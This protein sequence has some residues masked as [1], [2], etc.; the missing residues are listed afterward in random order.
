M[1]YTEMK[2]SVGVAILLLITLVIAFIGFIVKEKGYLEPSHSYHFIVDDAS[3]LSRGT[4]LNYSGFTVALINDIKLLESGKAQ[5]SFEL[6]QR[7][8]RWIRDNTVLTVKRPL[9]GSSYIVI[10]PID[11]NASILQPNGF[12]KVDMS[13]DINDIIERLEPIVQKATHTIDNITKITDY[14]ADDKSDLI[15]SIHNINQITYKLA[16][17][18]SLLT[19]LTGDSNA[20]QNFIISLNHLSKILTN[21]EK[22]SQDFATISGS[23]DP[24]IITPSSHAIKDVGRIMK[25]IRGKLRLLHGTIKEVG[26]YKHELKNIRHEISSGIHKSNKIINKVDRILG[27]NSNQKVELP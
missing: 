25:D 21:L 6:S 19:S 27:G 8:Q 7:N 14:L 18:D 17:N 20:T 4:P 13:N 11:M 1:Q 16:N 9:I 23:L 24:K 2:R 5:M 10:S 22:I 26:R 12:L 3:S 15:Q